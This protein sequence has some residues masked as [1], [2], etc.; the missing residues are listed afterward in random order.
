[1]D[2]SVINIPC[3]I[4][5]ESLPV[6]VDAVPVQVYILSHHVADTFLAIYS[7]ASACAKGCAVVFT[8]LL[9][10]LFLA[11]AA[12]ALIV[13]TVYA[14]LCCACVRPSR[15][16]R[17]GRQPAAGERGPGASTGAYASRTYR[18]SDQVYWQC[19]HIPSDDTWFAECNCCE[20]GCDECGED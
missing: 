11:C 18:A 19:D 10:P 6:V 17:S 16:A 1:M 20:G 14:L 15:R 12:L 3:E 13:D 5:S 9:F 8:P 2:G 7:P 4:L